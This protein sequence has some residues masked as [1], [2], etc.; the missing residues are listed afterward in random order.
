MKLTSWSKSVVAIVP[1]LLALG[2]VGCSSN[3]GNAGP[4]DI[5]HDLTVNDAGVQVTI[6]GAGTVTYD[7][8]SQPACTADGSQTSGQPCSL[9]EW[10]GGAGQVTAKAAPGWKFVGWTNSSLAGAGD[11]IT[12]PGDA[13]QT[14]APGTDARITA[15]FVLAIKPIHATFT[16]NAQSTTY[17]LD[18]ENKDLDPIRVQ[19]SGPNCGDWD[20]KTEV[21]GAE[22]TTTFEMTW[23]HPHPNCDATTDHSDVTIKATITIKDK[24]FVC[25]YKGAHDGDGTACQPQK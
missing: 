10:K 1:C 23:H 4:G 13:T 7:N 11:V 22:T 15:T 9:V 25:E 6:V 16:Q 8:S 24:K 2:A 3:G 14:I 18:I 19:W 21:F 12:K 20:P 5:G 17:R